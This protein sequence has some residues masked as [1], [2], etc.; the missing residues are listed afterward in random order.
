MMN[1]TLLLR[2]QYWNVSSGQN[3]ADVRLPDEEEESNKTILL[4]GSDKNR[5]LT[6]GRL[7]SVINHIHFISLT[8]MTTQCCPIRLT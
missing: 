2:I 4:I 6:L 7:S 3:I 1:E 5:V 8:H